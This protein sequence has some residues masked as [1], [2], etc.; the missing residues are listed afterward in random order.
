MKLRM[1][2][3]W[4]VLFSLSCTKEGLPGPQGPEGPEG[5]AGEPGSGGGGGTVRVIS[6]LT[7]VTAAYT[8]EQQT[9]TNTN[10]TFRLKWT[11]GASNGNQFIL[12]DSVGRMIDNGVLLV[13]AQEEKSTNGTNVWHQL[14]YNPTGFYDLETY[15]YELTKSGN[16][17]YR[18]TITILADM[19]KS[20]PAQVRTPLKYIR[21]KFVIIPKTETHGL[22]WG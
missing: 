3:L 22:G 10:V 21:L 2:F 11:D 7:P 13:Y 12:P 20:N 16:Q 17:Q 18:Y 14:L 1:L 19:L 15:T 6:F 8:W 9:M 5:P 4:G